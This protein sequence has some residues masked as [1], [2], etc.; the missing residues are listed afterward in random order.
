V[1]TVSI[2]HGIYKTLAFN[3]LTSRLNIRG[4]VLDV[5]RISGDT[6][7]GHVA[8]RVVVFLPPLKPAELDVSFRFSGLHVDTLLQLTRDESR[9]MSGLLSANGSLRGNESDALGFVHSLDGK[10]DFAIETGRIQ[11]GRVIPKII[12]ILNLPTLLQGKVDLGKDGL[13]FDKI[14]GSFTLSNGILTEDNLVIDSPVMKMSAAGNYDMAADQLDA[15]VVVSPFGSY[16]QL[17]KSIP[18]FG[19]LFKGEREGTA[20][21]EVKGPLQSPDV[22]YLPLRSFAKGITGLAQLAF[23]MLRNT[24]L[25]PKEII[26]PSD[27]PSSDGLRG[28]KSG[29][30]RPEPRLP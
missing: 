28:G 17:L 23:D 18:L 9:V 25:L 21:F 14:V 22:T 19:K 4:N 27:E 7:D 29:L 3:S 6:D 10:T 12:T 24:I 11:K 1:A 13:P 20:I 15:V 30:D 5:D 16:S 26:S 2:D 8:G